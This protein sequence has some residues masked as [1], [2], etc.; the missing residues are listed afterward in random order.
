[1]PRSC[2][3][4]ALAVLGGALLALGCN[5]NTTR[6][7]FG[8]LPQAVA[9]ELEL[10]MD[11]ATRMLADALRADSI[12]VDVV[13]DRDG[14]LESPWFSAREGTPTQARPVG[15]EIVRVRAWATPGR[16]GHTDL[17]V[18]TVY[19][20]LVDPS[21]PVRLLERHVSPEHPVARRLGAAVARLVTQFGDPALLPTRPTLRPDS[22]IAPPD[23]LVRPDTLLRPR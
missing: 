4:P 7:P 13:R 15:V 19:L 5:P 12:P 22:V 17:L 11:Y 23:T 20:P 1:M 6:P 10:P 14:Y 2:R 21:R 16:I 8:P 3:L 18:E 9:L